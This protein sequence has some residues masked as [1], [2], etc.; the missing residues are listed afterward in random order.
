MS[1]YDIEV[2]VLKEEADHAAISDNAR[3]GVML[4]D[5]KISI[6]DSIAVSVTFPSKIV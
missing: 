3:R 5:K 1:P 6:A 4:K 2:I